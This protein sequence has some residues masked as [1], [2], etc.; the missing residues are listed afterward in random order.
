MNRFRHRLMKR[1]VSVIVRDGNVVWVEVKGLVKKEDQEI[2]RSIVLEVAAEVM[3]KGTRNE[4]RWRRSK[5][6]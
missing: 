1:R 6:I 2:V 5:L 4:E 3:A